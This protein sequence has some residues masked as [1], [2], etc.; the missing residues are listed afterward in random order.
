[1]G[2]SPIMSRNSFSYY[3]SFVDHCTGFTWIYLLKHKSDVYTVF[4]QFKVMVENQFASKIM[5]LQSDWG[6]E[7]QGLS[8]FLKECDIIH[9]LFFPYTPQQNSLAERKYRHI[10]ET[11]LA[12]LSQ[13]SLPHKFWDDAFLIATNLINLMPSKTI[14]K[15]LTF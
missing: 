11:G 15:Y 9:R 13:A 3:I 6:G 5:I 2:P 14:K 10:V 1:M 4:K 12:L 8:S 7:F